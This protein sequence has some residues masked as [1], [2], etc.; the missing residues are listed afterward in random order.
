MK[1]MYC[2]IIII[3]TF[4]FWGGG[5]FV[6]SLYFNFITILICDSIKI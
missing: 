4:F 2:I 5:E 1:V 3:I 6:K